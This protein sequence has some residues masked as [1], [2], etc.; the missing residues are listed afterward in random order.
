MLG[1]LLHEQ[2]RRRPVPSFRTLLYIFIV[3]TIVFF[4]LW[5]FP[6][7]I[8]HSPIDWNRNDVSITFTNNSKSRYPGFIIH[9]NDNNKNTTSAASTQVWILSQRISVG[10]IWSIGS[11]HYDQQYGHALTSMAKS[12]PVNGTSNSYHIDLKR[13]YVLHALLRHPKLHPI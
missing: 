2:Q 8:Y 7:K 13:F 5:M 9:N 4:P 3:L 12:K 10:M 1:F 11:P 6:I